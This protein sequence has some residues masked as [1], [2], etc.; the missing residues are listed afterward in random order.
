MLQ[1]ERANLFWQVELVAVVDRTHRLRAAHEERCR[2]SAVTRLAGA[3]LL[4]EFLLR[5]ID[6][7]ASQHLVRS[8]AALRKLPD[9]HALDEIHARL[10]AEDLVLEL[11]LALRFVVEAEKFRF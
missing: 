7:A 11:D 6:F 8:R 3:F 2:A 9:D 5:A 10:E 1:A 4:V